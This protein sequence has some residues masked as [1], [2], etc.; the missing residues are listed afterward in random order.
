MAW[1][2]ALGNTIDLL[3]T[4]LK[5]YGLPD[6]GVS[7]WIAG[8][9]TI[10]TGKQLAP[11]SSAYYPTSSQAPA[12]LNYTPAP[13]QGSGYSTQYASNP[14]N[15]SPPA[16]SPPSG[17]SN[18]N[19]YTTYVNVP[20][21]GSVKLADLL[22]EGYYNEKT[23]PS[24]EDQILNAGYDDY[25]RSLDEQM[26][27]LDQQ[28]GNQ[29]QIAQNTYNQGLNTVNNQRGQGEVDLLNNRSKTLRD[30]SSNLQSSWQQGNAYLGTRGASDSSA[31]S[32]Y[33]Y[34]LTKMGNQQRG[35][36]QGQYDQNLFK[37]K[38]TYDTEV[39]NLELQKNNQIQQISQWFAEA[40]NS[41]RGQKGQAA[42]QKSQQA[43]SMAMQAAQQV[44]QQSAAQQ[45]ALTQWAANHAT[46]F[47]QL[48]QQLGQIS[49][50]Q[51][52]IP[53]FQ[54]IT[55]GAQG[56]QGVTAGYGQDTRE[57]DLFGNIR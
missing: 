46:S 2:Q 12:P 1:Q 50:F 25:F 45:Q 39:K 6:L 47:G 51:G 41:L 56:P 49:Q 16:Q 4:P 28:R 53:A 22:A 55:G 35:D 44:Q 30:L 5:Q 31:A 32:Q 18:Q 37:L 19:P 38:N 8:G 27:G 57:K 23:G 48:G 11:Q 3:S 7:E 40:Q 33:A 36:V 29:E 24:R 14:K 42:L 10:N 15:Y 54:G 9:P 21:R 26:G 13:I 34:A 20:G 52:S 17:Q 43:L